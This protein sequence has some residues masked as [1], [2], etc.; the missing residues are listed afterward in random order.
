[1]PKTMRFAGDYD[2]LEQIACWRSVVGLR[3]GFAAVRPLA[4]D[5]VPTVATEIL[6]NR[7][8]AIG[9]MTWLLNKAHTGC[10]HARMI[11]IEIIRLQ[12]QKHP[13]PG[14]VTNAGHLCRTVGPCQ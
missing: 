13:P 1:M 8:D 10:D 9:L 2:A 11:A 4:L 5:Q 6:E 12:E 7:D 3:T 14:L